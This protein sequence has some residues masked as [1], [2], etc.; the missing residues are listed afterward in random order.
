VTNKIL[1]E[2]TIAKLLELPPQTREELLEAIA[3]MLSTR[4][5]KSYERE[6]DK[7]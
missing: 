2:E 5:D 6:P 7:Q 4:V 1:S 3:K